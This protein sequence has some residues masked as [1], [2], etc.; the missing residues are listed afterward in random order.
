[1][2]ELGPAARILDTLGPDE[3]EAAVARMRGAIERYL[4]GGAVVF[5]AAA[6]I[7]TATAV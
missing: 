3:R 5:P 2:S 4:V 1:L 7:W 6:W